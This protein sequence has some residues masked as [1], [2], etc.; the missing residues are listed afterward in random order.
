[1]VDTI[2]AVLMGCFRFRQFT[3]SRWLT[4]GTSTRIVVVAVLL[5]MDALYEH[6]KKDWWG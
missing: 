1:M 5:G 6:L 2:V 3:E 4:I